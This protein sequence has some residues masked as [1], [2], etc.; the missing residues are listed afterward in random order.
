MTITQS[1]WAKGRNN[2]PYPSNAGAV[3]AVRCSITVPTTM[4]ANDIIELACLPGG[5]TLVDAILDSDDLDTG[6]PAIVWD[7][8]LMSGA[9]QDDAQDRTCGN[10]LFAASAVSQAGGAVR[11]TKKEAFR[12]TA[13]GA[14][15]SIGLK[16]TTVAATAAAGVIG[17][18]LFYAAG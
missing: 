16:L 18:T 8:G 5:H 1:D 12:I 3:C 9:W 10:E 15:R 13:A 6:T 4:S 7:V 11:P 14:D 17:L 2:V